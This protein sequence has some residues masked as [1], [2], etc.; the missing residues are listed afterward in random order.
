M[1]DFDSRA[2]RQ[3][4]LFDSKGQRK[5]LNASERQAFAQAMESC[6]D[7][8]RKAFCL[9][10]YHTGCRI[11]EGLRLTAE[12]VDMS[13]KAVV[14]ETL[15]RRKQ[16]CFRAVPIPD[17]LA[18]MLGT[19]IAG[20]ASPARLWSFSRPTAYRLVM[21]HMAQAGISGKMASPKGLR[22]AFG[23]ACIERGIPL[24]TVK[25][26]LG[27]ARLETTAIYLDVM[28]GEERELAKRLWRAEEKP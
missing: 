1:S 11:S 10:L 2:G 18:C 9:T 8:L 28:G 20:L 14:F 19:I 21:E 15:K 4:V 5:Y 12:R 13:E 25:K 7:E 24:T 22:H 16:R 3:A 26:W 17:E 23:I 6:S 27:H